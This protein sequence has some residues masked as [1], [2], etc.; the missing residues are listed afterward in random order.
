MNFNVKW[1]HGSVR[2]LNY[3][4]SFDVEKRAVMM[5]FTVHN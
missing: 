1:E 3:N 2:V 4:I 5:Q